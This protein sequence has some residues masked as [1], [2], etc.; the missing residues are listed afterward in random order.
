MPLTTQ[1]EHIFLWFCLFNGILF[2]LDTHSV[3]FPL[4]SDGAVKILV[5]MGCALS[6]KYV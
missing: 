3:P 2:I 6:R 1:M 5:I 4:F